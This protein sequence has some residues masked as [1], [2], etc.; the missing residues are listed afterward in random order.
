MQASATE[1]NQLID[2]IKQDANT[3]YNDQYVFAGAATGAQPYQAGSSDA[4]AGGTGQVTRTIGPNTS[5]GINANLY[6]VLGSGQT[7]P[8][9]PAG[10][11]ALLST[12]RNIAADMTSGNSGALNGT[13]LSQLDANFSAPSPTLT[14][15]MGATS[16]RLDMAAS[17]I[18]SLQ[19]SDTQTLSGTQ[20]ADMAQTEIN[21]STQQ[22][23]L[24]AALQ[25][26]ANI[27]Q[28]S[29]MDFLSG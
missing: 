11:G 13:D 18:Q 1:V 22:A 19:A 2:E 4:Y 14:S 17:R 6:S 3:Q 21:Y 9:Q 27:V 5:L 10:D 15:G 29:L 7:A 20:D 25:A 26:G 23:A 8:V 24:T 16:D 12:L 28:Q